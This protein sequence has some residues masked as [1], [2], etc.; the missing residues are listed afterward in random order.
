M[1]IKFKELDS[2][3]SEL[4]FKKFLYETNEERKVK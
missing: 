3:L 1:N 4:R 2:D